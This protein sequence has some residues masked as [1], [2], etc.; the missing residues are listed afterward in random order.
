M[1]VNR[2]SAFEKHEAKKYN[3]LL[4][5]A[6]IDGDVEIFIVN[7]LDNNR[8]MNNNQLSNAVIKLYEV[9]KKYSY[10]HISNRLRRL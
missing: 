7:M 1:K 3:K 5:T 6:D 10:G 4:N 2:E 9:Y 8:I